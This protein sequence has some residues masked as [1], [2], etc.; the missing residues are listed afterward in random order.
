MKERIQQRHRNTEEKKSEILETKTI[1]KSKSL[2]INKK[3]NTNKYK[4]SFPEVVEKIEASSSKI[5]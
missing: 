3:V 4:L 1:S 5:R 2:Y